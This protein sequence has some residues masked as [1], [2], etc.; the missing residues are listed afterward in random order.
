MNLYLRLPPPT[1]PDAHVSTRYLPATKCTGE[2]P[3]TY[4][5]APICT[6]SPPRDLV[7]CAPAPEIHQRGP[8]LDPAVQI[9]IKGGPEMHQNRSGDLF[10]CKRGC[11][12][13]SGGVFWCKRVCVHTPA[14]LCPCRSNAILRASV[15][16][17]SA[18]KPKCEKSVAMH[19]HASRSNK[20]NSSQP[21]SRH[22]SEQV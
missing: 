7:W 6:G 22:P 1:P 13:R 20:P 10:W 18:A 11:V 5:P 21:P 19:Q 4:L 3:K 15:M 17:G 12:L 9:L 2:N 8:F 14:R 16:A